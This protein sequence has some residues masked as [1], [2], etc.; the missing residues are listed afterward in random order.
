MEKVKKGIDYSKGKIYRIV[1]DTTGL[2]YIGSTVET[3]SKRLTKHK[4]KYKQY[5]KGNTNF[6]TSFDIIKN[7]NYKIILLENCPCNSKEELHKIERKYIETIECVNKVIPGRTRKEYFEDNKNKLNEKNKEY[8]E[9]N[10]DKIKEQKKEWYETNK[11]KMKE[12]KKE[13]NKEYYENN[14]DKHKEYYETNKDKILEQKK[15][16]YET[17][18]TEINEKIECEYCK[19]I[20]NKY[21]LKKHQKTNKCLKLRT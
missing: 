15:E 4:D 5:L 8:R 16:Y 3:L 17:N 18:K 1:C 7:D 9:K 14:K 20:V 13:K 6:V 12:Q 21:K 19:S 11:D 2:T 10:K